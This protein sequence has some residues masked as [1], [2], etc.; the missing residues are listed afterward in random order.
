MTVVRQWAGVLRLVGPRRSASSVFTG[1]VYTNPM[2]AAEYSIIESLYKIVGKGDLNFA[3]RTPWRG[4]EINKQIRYIT[5]YFANGNGF[6]FTG[7]ALSES[8]FQAIGY[9]FYL[10]PTIIIK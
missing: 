7:N 1:S 5:V 8:L 6:V 9:P 10:V 4:Y 3:R 2:F